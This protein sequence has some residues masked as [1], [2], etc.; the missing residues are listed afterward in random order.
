M[1]IFDTKQ[2]NINLLKI[3]HQIIVYCC[4][5]NHHLFDCALYNFIR[6]SYL[7]HYQQKISSPEV[8]TIF[9][10]VNS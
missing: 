1:K 9:K 8:L 10:L 4:K 5:K 2:E 7:E 6:I 3:Y